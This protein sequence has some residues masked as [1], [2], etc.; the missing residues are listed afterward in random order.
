ML[1]FLSAIVQISFR[2]K[3]NQHSARCLLR[4]FSQS[5]SQ[6]LNHDR[7]VSVFEREVKFHII[8]SF[9]DHHSNDLARV[10]YVPVFKFMLERQT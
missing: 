7:V 5:K 9:F 4:K 6:L 1:P 2:W 8:R 10:D 3:E